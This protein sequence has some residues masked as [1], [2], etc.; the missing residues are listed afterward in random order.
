MVNHFRLG[1]SR[2][3]NRRHHWREI[4]GSEYDFWDARLQI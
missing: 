1:G 3:L 2:L 4:K